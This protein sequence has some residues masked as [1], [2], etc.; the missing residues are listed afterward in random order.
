MSALISN[1]FKRLEARLLDLQLAPAR[2]P[3]PQ[4]WP[5]SGQKRPGDIWRSGVALGEAAW[6]HGWG[7]WE[8][9]QFCEGLWAASG[10][11]LS[12]CACQWRLVPWVW[13][14]EN[15]TRSRVTEQPFE[16]PNTTALCAHQRW[17][18]QEKL[19]PADVARYPHVQK[20]RHG[21]RSFLCVSYIRAR[22]GALE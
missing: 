17:G 13:P 15:T 22:L 16:C 20:R 10:Q 12:S 11:E 4:L 6:E 8:I 7:C 9:T 5:F 3:V 2:S 14:C 18:G 1:F 21:D 19:N